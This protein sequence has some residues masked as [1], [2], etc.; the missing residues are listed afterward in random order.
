MIPF[1]VG[2]SCWLWLERRLMRLN[3]DIKVLGHKIKKRNN[4][5]CHSALHFSP[6]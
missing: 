5:L 1:E 2:D 4:E 6:F 3:P